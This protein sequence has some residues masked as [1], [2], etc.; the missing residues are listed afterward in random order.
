M[1]MKTEEE[2]EDEEKW[3]EEEEDDEGVVP[4]ADG[5]DA[6][7]PLQLVFK[8]FDNSALIYDSCKQTQPAAIAAEEHVRAFVYVS[9]LLSDR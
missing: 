6:L 8:L 7:F 5:C 1:R 2:E 4:S 9:S 3:Q